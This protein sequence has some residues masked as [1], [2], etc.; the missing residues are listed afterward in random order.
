MPRRLI[1]ALLILFLVFLIAQDATG[2][3]STARAF[4]GWVNSG[5]DTAFDFIDALFDDT[6]D[7]AQ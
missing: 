4:F 2:T 6:A 5:V 7:A 1:Y 3:G